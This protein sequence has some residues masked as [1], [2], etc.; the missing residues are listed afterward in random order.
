MSGLAEQDDIDII[1]GFENG[2]LDREKSLEEALGKLSS[3]D[4]NLTSDLK[5]MSMNLKNSL[6]TESIINDKITEIL[7]KQVTGEQEVNRIIA[8]LDKGIKKSNKKSEKVSAL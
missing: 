5:Q 7:S 4:A 8:I 1:K 2:L 6:K 3:R